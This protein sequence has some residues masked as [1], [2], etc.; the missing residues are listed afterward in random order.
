VTR[1]CGHFGRFE[2]ASDSPSAPP[3]SSGPLA[4]LTRDP[5]S[6]PAPFGLVLAAFAV[7][8]VAAVTIGACAEAPVPEAGAGHGASRPPNLLVILADD[9]G[10][11]DLGCYGGEPKTPNIDRLAAQGARFT[12]FYAGAPV[13]SPSRASLFT[14]LLAPHTGVRQPVQSSRPGNR[15]RTDLAFLPEL[16]REA[17]YRTAL[18]GKWHLGWEPP[19]LPND[20]GFDEFLGFLSQSRYRTER[21]LDNGSMVELEGNLTELVTERAL[22]LL[23]EAAIEGAPPLFLVVSHLA[24]HAPIEE[25]ASFLPERVAAHVAGGLPPA[26]AMYRAVV[27]HLDG[28]VGE[29]LQALSRSGLD[30]TTLVVFASDNGPEAGSPGPFRGGKW[31]LYEGGLRVPCVVRWPGRVPAGLAVE[32]LATMPDL[33]STLL[34]AAGVAVPVSNGAASLT[35]RSLLPVMTAAKATG[36][37]AL[38]ED[39]AL[40]WR[41]GPAEA[42]R[43]GPWKL[44]RARNGSSTELYDVLAD[45]GERRNLAAE[46]PALVEELGAALDR[47]LSGA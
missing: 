45:P 28:E 47:L 32:G 30:E 19:D 24:P 44:V 13:C 20:R 6:S 46:R 43:R 41:H 11:G 2:A 16:L 8:A 21:L 40:A 7:A 22:S 12:S 26:R 33:F 42:L 18:V 10:Y 25:A 27:E 5:D 29:L 1:R 39:R 23:G 34:A 9:L 4:T 31:G 3:A 17:G 38:A 37:E 35:G 36:G 15:L 14:G